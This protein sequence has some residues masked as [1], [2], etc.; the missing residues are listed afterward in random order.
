MN[1]RKARLEDVEKNLLNLYVDGFEYHHTGR[2]DIFP[3]RNRKEL[4]EDLINT[5]NNSHILV[6]EDNEEILGYVVY[7]LKEKRDKT[8][9]IDELVVDKDNRH[10]GNGKK[11][12]EK[13]K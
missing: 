10:S 8:L 12:M 3:S 4:K 2:P 13:I 7:Q 5:I 11:L 9:W 6:L 1:I